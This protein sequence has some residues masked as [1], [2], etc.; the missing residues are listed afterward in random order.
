M[1]APV[2]SSYA[3]RLYC[4][5]AT[6]RGAGVPIFEGFSRKSLAHGDFYMVYIYIYVFF[7]WMSEFCLN[8][9]DAKRPTTE[10]SHSNPGWA[11]DWLQ[12]PRCLRIHNFGGEEYA[13]LGVSRYGAWKGWII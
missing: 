4:K 9:S 1:M 2:A 3:L 7:L 11:G 10:Q 8:S 6:G 13:P 5:G 12:D